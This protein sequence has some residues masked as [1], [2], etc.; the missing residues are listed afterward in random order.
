[1]ILYDH[2][3]I[4]SL[5]GFNMG[6][7]VSINTYEKFIISKDDIII[8][9]NKDFLGLVGYTESELVGRTLIEVSKIFRTDPQVNLQSIEDDT[10]IFLFTKELVAIE[11]ILS[12]ETIDNGAR[13]V[14]SFKRD[15]NDLINEK[16][17][18]AN[19]FA[20]SRGDGVALLSFS[21]EQSGEILI[22]SNQKYLDSLKP[23]YNIRSNSI[24]KKIMKIVPG[25]SDIKFNYIKEH[26][27]KTSSPYYMKEMCTNFRSLGEEYWDVNLVPILD[28][29][30]I[31]YILL[32]LSNVTEE[33]FNRKAI[34]Q[35]NEELEAIIE[36]MSD[37]IIIFDKNFDVISINKA[38]EKISS[39]DNTSLNNL[40]DIIKN[41]ITYDKDNKLISYGNFPSQ[42]VAR[43][44]FISDFVIKVNDSLGVIYRAVSG[45]PVFDREGNFSVGV[46]VYRDI[47]DRSRT[48]EDRLIKTQ[49]ELLSKVVEALDLE[50]IRC[51]YPE[52]EIIS[53]NGNGFKSLI[54]MNNGIKSIG[55]PIGQSYFTIYPIYEEGKRKELNHYLIEKGE[56]SYIDY[57]NHTIGGV[58]RF[59]KTI[60]QP[61][62]G[63]NN[64]I[65]EIIFITTDI[66]DEVRAKNKIEETL[67]MQNQM[68]STISHELKTP[69]SIIFSAS[70][71]IE[72]YLKEEINKINKEDISKNISTIKQNCYRFIKLINNIIDLSSIESGFYRLRFSNENIIEIVEG[73]VD[74]VRSFVEDK[75]LSIVFDTEIEEM[76]I[77]VDVDKM[78]RIILN[79][80]SNAVKFSPKNENI[81]IDIKAKKDFVEILVRDCGMGID[82]I[83]LNTIFDKYKKVDN[84]LSRNAEG[85]G[86]G[87]ALVKTMVEIIG[88]EISVESELGKGSLFTVKLPVKVSDEVEVINNIEHLDNRIER[89]NIEFSDVYPK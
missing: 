71:V 45:S 84:S 85:S 19:Q 29:G 27:R 89:M 36:N 49:N 43:G 61:I 20:T 9:V 78:E 70:Q 75:G 44:E 34:K 7:I 25:Y 73:I 1:M 59:Y 16:F 39:I 58:Q 60:N 69:L 87:L 53:I 31:K 18:L 21:S 67:E 57:T 28:D 41:S 3:Y 88:G 46:M 50:F 55:Y 32:S 86:I 11:G 12:C 17:N 81:Y 66:T 42:R 8:K 22:N 63:L 56:Y 80:I 68:F 40:N 62:F 26:F 47:E 6:G 77:A 76:T 23:P 13:R 51:T 30:I 5:G 52:L 38:M 48:V 64:K 54:E 37:E 15:N 24:G 82:K 33:V 10:S 72:M 4:P 2:Y 79:L 65:V 83:H 35:K 14:F 74:S